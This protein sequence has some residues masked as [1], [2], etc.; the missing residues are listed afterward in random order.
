MDDAIRPR[1]GVEPKPAI[2]LTPGE[3]GIELCTRSRRTN[4]NTAFQHQCGSLHV[5]GCNESRDV[6]ASERSALMINTPDR[7]VCLILF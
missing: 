3:L 1:S 5:V 6:A 2:A 4:G 7:H